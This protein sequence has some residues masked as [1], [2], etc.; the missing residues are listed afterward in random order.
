MDSVLNGEA[1]KYHIDASE[2]Q[3]RVTEWKCILFIAVHGSCC[4]LVV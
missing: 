2:I 3:P 4:R 1:N